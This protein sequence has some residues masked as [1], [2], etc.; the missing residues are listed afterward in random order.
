MARF[1][2][3]GQGHDEYG[4]PRMVTRNPWAA[5][6]VELLN[7]ASAEV[8]EAHE[9]VKG[10]RMLK[11]KGPKEEPEDLAMHEELRWPNRQKRNPQLLIESDEYTRDFTPV[12]LSETEDSDFEAMGTDYNDTDEDPDVESD[13]DMAQGDFHPKQERIQD[14]DGGFRLQSLSTKA[15]G[16]SYA[17]TDRQQQEAF[18]QD[19]IVLRHLLQPRSQQTLRRL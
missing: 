7:E 3:P 4:H 8:L 11:D 16:E 19:D 13:I 5:C 1:T 12:D 15:I 2:T 9:S 6:L 10:K 14:G 17:T 18:I